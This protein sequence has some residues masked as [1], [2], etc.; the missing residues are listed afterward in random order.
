MHSIKLWHPAFSVV[1]DLHIVEELFLPS[2]I[3][4]SFAKTQGARF[5]DLG[6]PESLSG[7]IAA[8]RA[9][10]L[11]SAQHAPSNVR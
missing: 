1:T 3:V 6:L 2:G 8:S 5:L 9:P 11:R 10:I 4:H 7:T